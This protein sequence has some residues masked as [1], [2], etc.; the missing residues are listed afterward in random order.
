MLETARLQ[1]DDGR[2]RLDGE[3]REPVRYRQLTA[4]VDVVVGELR[5][6]LGGTFT[7]AELALAYDR[8]EDWVR[9]AVLQATP[10][11]AK[12]GLHDAALIQ[13]AAFAAYARG[14]VDYAP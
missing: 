4:L 13:D 9:E 5:R 6:R 11:A 12:A 7:L 8:S 10:P 2:R 1:W 3:R 14:A